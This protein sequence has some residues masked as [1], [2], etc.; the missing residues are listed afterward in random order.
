MH[1]RRA[2][3]RLYVLIGDVRMF[4]EETFE[5]AVHK[6]LIHD[7]SICRALFKRDTLVLPP[8]CPLHVSLGST[9]YFLF[10]LSLSL[11]KIPISNSLPEVEVSS[12]VTAAG[13]SSRIGY[14]RST[15]E[16]QAIKNSRRSYFPREAK[17]EKRWRSSPRE[18]SA[19]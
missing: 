15:V 11:E 6:L 12:I 2:L 17:R 4:P 16:L 18:R 3:Y 19:G 10:S 13:W 14:S 5:K 7:L 1:A 8:R 9:T